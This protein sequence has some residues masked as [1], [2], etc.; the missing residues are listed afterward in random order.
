[1]AEQQ[2]RLAGRVY[3][4]GEWWGPGDE[5]RMPAHVAASI[6]NPAAWRTDDA[7][8]DEQQ[9]RQLDDD[10]TGPRLAGPVYA[11]GEWWKPGDEGRMPESVRSLISNPAAWRDGKVPDGTAR[12]AV[13]PQEQPQEQPESEDT[14]EGQDPNAQPAQPEQPEQSGE[15]ETARQASTTRRHRGSRG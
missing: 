2:R 8:E 1:M 10:Y 6:K 4:G 11:G 15:S 14:G 12:A 3:A 13:R 9:R 7:D 5:K